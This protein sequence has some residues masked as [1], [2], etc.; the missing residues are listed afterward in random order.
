[1]K[2]KE[3]GRKEEREG[4]M[5]GGKREKAGGREVFAGLFHLPLL[6]SLF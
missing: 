2:E 1:M 5:E 4:G 6:F 3:K